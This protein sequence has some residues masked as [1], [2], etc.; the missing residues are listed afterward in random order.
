MSFTPNAQPTESIPDRSQAERQ[1]RIYQRH[2]EVWFDRFDDQGRCNHEVLEDRRQPLWHAMGFLASGDPAAITKA[3]AILPQY[4]TGPSTLGGH[5]WGS[6]MASLLKR[7]GDQLENSTYNRLLEALAQQ[8]PEEG[9]H[10]F[11]GYNDNFPAMAA[12]TAIVGGEL[13]DQP[14]AVAQGVACLRGLRS[15]LRRRGFYS[16]YVSPTYSAITLTCLAEIAELARDAE[17]RELALNAEQRMWTELC[18]RFHPATSMIAGPYS[19]A[20]MADLCGHP[21]NAHI[22]LYLALGDAVFVNPLTAVFVEDDEQALHGGRRMLAGH[23]CWHSVATYHPPAYAQTLALNRPNPGVVEADTEAAG[24]ARN[25]WQ[26][27]RHPQ[28]P[29]AEFQAHDSH[30]TTWSDG[31]LAL[32]TSSRPFLD[33]YQH[34]PLHLLYHRTDETTLS[35]VTTAFPKYFVGEPQLSRHDHLPDGGRTLCVQSQNTAV[36]AAWPKAGWGVQPPTADPTTDAV[37]ELSQALLFTCFYGH[38]PD[39]VWLGD[40]RCETEG[41]SPQPCPVFIADGPVFI[42][43]Y[44]LAIDD[45]GRDA[46]VRYERRDGF[47]VLRF[48]NYRGAA[49]TFGAGDLPAVRNGFVVQ[50]ERAEV[51]G[52]D[53]AGFRASH[54]KTPGVVR[55]RWVPDDVTRFVSFTRGDLR[56]EMEFS[57]HSEGIKQRSVNDN[58]LRTPKLSLGMRVDGVPWL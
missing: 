17:A 16:E 36:M 21:H 34:A 40:H 43:L 20:Y 22:V 25:T 10:R 35:G 24:M 54:E 39:E 48:V 19:R 18:S 1:Q 5:F 13:T 15:M 46:A 51:W 41:A 4:L 14:D 27:D 55:D 31:P 38:A 32:G 12:L 23:T 53:F 52:D 6:A 42:A 8:A 49:R 58:L 2:L 26:D 7:F 9:T 50:A 3:N 45:L 11:R 44:P 29:Y 47:A 57:P 30:L 28:T 37:K 56:M 33:S